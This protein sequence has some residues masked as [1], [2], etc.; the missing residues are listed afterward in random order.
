MRLLDEAS[1]LVFEVGPF[2]IARMG[3]D[4][5]VERA[6]KRFCELLGYTEEELRGKTFPELTHPD[7]VQG[8]VELAEQALRGDLTHYTVEKRYLKKSGEAV[9]TQLTATYVRDGTDGSVHG[10][11]MIEDISERKASEE[12]FVALHEE[13]KGR[14][15]ELEASNVALA[16]ANKELGTFSS[17]VSHDLKGPLISIAQ[18]SQILLGRETGPIND[19]QDEML[20]RIRNAGLQAK[21]IIDDLRDLADVTRREIFAEEVDMSAMCWTIIEDLRGLAP[22]RDVTFDIRPDLRVYA[23]PALLRLLMVNLIQNAWK[24][25]APKA[26]VTIQVGVERGSLGTIFFVKDDGIGFDNEHRERIFQ[27]FERLHTH[28]FAGTG[29]GLATAQRIVQRHGGDIWA[30]GVP[31]EGATFWFSM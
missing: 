11:A 31:G 1:D 27:A 12:R 9:W 3:P 13:L 5:R 16:K 4:F 15:T 18:F 22:E 14:I 17:N 28:E 7:D 30:E 26:H 21:N 6:S 25:S 2:A 29:L 19:A 23:D 20:R 8:N 24:Y 10:L